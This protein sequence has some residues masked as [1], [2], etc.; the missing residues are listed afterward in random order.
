MSDTRISSAT[1][2]T[3][4]D[5]SPDHR[6]RDRFWPYVDVPEEPTDAELAALDPDVHDVLFGRTERPFSI[7]VSFPVFDGDDYQRAVDMARNASEYW[8]I[9]SGDALRHRARFYLRDAAQLRE[10]FEVV[11]ATEGCEVLIDDRPVPYARE[12][13]L[14]LVWVLL[15]K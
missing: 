5:N 1:Q 3:L 7:T 9:G 11:D 13:W 15:L 2:R 4:A 10:L 14:P 8:T 12:L 6:P